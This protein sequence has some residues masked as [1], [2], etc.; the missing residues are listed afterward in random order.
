MAALDCGDHEAAEVTEPTSI[1]VCMI[2]LSHVRVYN[3]VFTG[4]IEETV[5]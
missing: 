3:I 2:N 1:S 5:P 4:G